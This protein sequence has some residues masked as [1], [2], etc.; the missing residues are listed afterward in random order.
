[1]GGDFYDFCELPG[2]SPRLGVLVADVT[3]KGIPAALFMALSRTIIRAMAV[4]GR[5]P[6]AALANANDL[7][8]NDSRSDLWLT[9]VYAVLD[10]ASGRLIYA[11]AG[12]SRPFWRHAAGGRVDEL[13]ARGIL[14]GAF[15]DITLDEQRIDV[16]PGDVLVF[17]TDGITDALNPEGQ[18]FGEERLAAFLAEHGSDGAEAIMVALMSEIAAFADGAEQADDITCVIVKRT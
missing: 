3:D 12:H 6:A 8:L 1:V 17:Y 16:Q 10:P 2:D 14:I 4:S 15:E 5:G 9:A 7:I 18:L 11:N 13:T